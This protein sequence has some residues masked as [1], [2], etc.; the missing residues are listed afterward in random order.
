MLSMIRDV[1]AYLGCL[2]E[3]EP[4][5]AEWAPLSS[6]VTLDM[7][8]VFIF[9]LLSITLNRGPFNEFERRKMLVQD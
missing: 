4:I 2:S 6:I 1:R 8:H 3:E 7:V 9:A 5:L